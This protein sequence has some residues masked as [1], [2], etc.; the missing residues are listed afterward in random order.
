M[1][2]RSMVDTL[3]STSL[4]YSSVP[5]SDPGCWTAW[6]TVYG[7]LKC[8]TIE[9]HFFPPSWIWHLMPPP[10]LRSWLSTTPHTS[11]CS[12]IFRSQF[13]TECFRKDNISPWCAYSASKISMK[14]SPH[15]SRECTG[16][17]TSRIFDWVPLV[18]SD[19]FPS[20][21]RMDSS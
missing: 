7:K 16:S 10:A 18:L 8:Q 13:H 4:C 21:I 3:S 12:R 17:S 5:P 14:T 15:D 6:T 11:P 1:T 9:P 19:T 2:A 20:R